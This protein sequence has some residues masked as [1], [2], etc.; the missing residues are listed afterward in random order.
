M[1]VAFCFSL[2]QALSAICARRRKTRRSFD[3]RSSSRRTVPHSPVLLH[4]G[5]VRHAQQRFRK[6]CKEHESCRTLEN[7]LPR[8]TYASRHRMRFVS[9]TK[10]RVA[11]LQVTTRRRRAQSSGQPATLQV[12]RW[13][14][15]LQ[16]NLS[17]VEVIRGRD[18]LDASELCR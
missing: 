5:A 10:A 13:S 9:P 7:T 2:S 18:G 16:R 3:N 15:S 17:D 6:E 4:T 8:H 14:C 1:I 11:P 12:R